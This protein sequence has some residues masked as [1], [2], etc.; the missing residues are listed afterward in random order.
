MTVRSI[1]SYARPSNDKGKEIGIS[2][3]KKNTEQGNGVKFFR[4]KAEDGVSPLDGVNMRGVFGEQGQ[5]N[6]IRL[7]PDSVVPNH[8]HPHEQLGMILEGEQILI[9]EGVEHRLGPLD[10]YVLPG[11]I[12]HGGRGGPEGCL[13][14]DI[15]VPCRE[16]Y[17]PAEATPVGDL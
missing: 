13:S 5:L 9:V 1:G 7:D 12:E 6:V 3:E 15:F 16:D 10:A 4:L 17:R 2:D 14:I 8:D 11:G